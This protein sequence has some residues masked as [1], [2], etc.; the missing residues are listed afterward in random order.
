V[1][2]QGFWLGFS[3]IV[4][5]VDWFESFLDNLTAVTVEDVHRVANTCLPRRNRTVGY[6]VPQGLASQAVPAG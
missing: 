4:A 5:D 2:N 3:S 6:Y 1:T